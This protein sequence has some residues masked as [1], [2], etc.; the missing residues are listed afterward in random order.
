MVWPGRLL[1]LLMP[2]DSYI[3]E[4]ADRLET[5]ESQLVTV[6][7][8][9]QL[10]IA[11]NQ[12]L[13]RQSELSYVP[14]MPDGAISQLQ[15]FSPSEPGSQFTRK[16]THSMSEGLHDHYGSSQRLTL[17]NWP[18]PDGSRQPPHASGL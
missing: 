13:R 4:L 14:G 10:Q 6:E 5:V 7:S 15:D 1:P 12:Q 16:R 3:K 9:L 2:F 11:E 18:A 17:N 8:Q